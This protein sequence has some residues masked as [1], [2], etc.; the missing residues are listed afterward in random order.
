VGGRAQFRLP[1]VILTLLLVC[2]P[3]AEA[4]DAVSGLR[5]A[6]ADT[7]LP[8]F[9]APVEES[10][11]PGL[12]LEFSP[13]DEIDPRDE[14]A[15]QPH[16]SEETKQDR[17]GGDKADA[18]AAQP[19]PVDRATLLAQL[20][21]RLPAAPD[22]GAA[23]ALMKTIEQVWRTS[24][25]DT[26]NL[27]MSR[28]ERLIKENDPELALKILDA[29]VDVVPDVAEAYYMRA[30]MAFEQRDYKRAVPDLKRAIELDPKHYK[31]L[32]DLGIAQ[33]ELGERKEALANFRKAVAVNPFLEQ[34]MRE[35]ELL[36][37]EV[38]GQE[39]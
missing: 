4:S 32:N 27:L 18:P 33:F 35:V 22:I 30:R 19:V 12:D 17:L 11:E 16:S 7:D 20:Y 9:H 26:A 21:E 23:R 34:A 6:Q 5:L 29:T 39:L 28:A 10:E 31:A 15:P 2:A 13:E 3:R 8:P 14:I 38:E 25:S 1:L 37:R 36:E 24:E